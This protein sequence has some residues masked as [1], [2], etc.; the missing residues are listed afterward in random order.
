MDG[1]ERRR[2]QKKKAILQAAMDLFMAHG[3]QK[4]SVAEIADKANVSQVTIYNYFG[5]KHNLVEEAIVYCIHQIWSEYEA[6]FDSDLPFIDKIRNAMFFKIRSTTNIHPDTFAAF[7]Q[8]YASGNAF[9]ETFLQEKMMPRMVALI[10]DGKR[11]GYVDPKLSNESILMFFQMFKEY[12][13]KEEVYPHLQRMTED[14]TKLFFY[15][16]VGQKDNL[17]D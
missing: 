8:K 9:L 10:E 17:L 14:L 12:M 16:L 11:E 15:G 4:V 5:N 2:E 1:F 6:L 13:Q 7:L 3:T